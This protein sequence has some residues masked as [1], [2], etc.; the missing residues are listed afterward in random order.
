MITPLIIRTPLKS[1][2]SDMLGHD[3]GVFTLRE[4]GRKNDREQSHRRREDLKKRMYWRHFKGLR[5]GETGCVQTRSD[6]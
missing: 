2:T 6:R 1:K 3:G 4:G 5:R